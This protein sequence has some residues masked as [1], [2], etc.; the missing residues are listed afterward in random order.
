[1]FA[2]AI[3]L[4]IDVATRLKGSPEIA[5]NYRPP[6]TDDCPARICLRHG[7]IRAGNRLIDFRGL[8]YDGLV[9]RSE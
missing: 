7:L 9:A 5:V 1:M 4:S 6:G 8:L 3:M 2:R